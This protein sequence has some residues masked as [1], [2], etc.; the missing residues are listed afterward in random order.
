MQQQS[1]PQRTVNT[2]HPII[3]PLIYTVVGI[4]AFVMLYI[5]FVPMY[6][7]R[8]PACADLFSQVETEALFDAHEDTIAELGSLGAQGGMVSE[9]PDCPGKAEIL[10]YHGT[11]Q[12]AVKIRKSLGDTFFG[13]PYRLVNN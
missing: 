8:N 5:F 11:E 2:S 6:V 3:R 4:F 1:Q 10:I 7:N 12:Q 13:A 9:R